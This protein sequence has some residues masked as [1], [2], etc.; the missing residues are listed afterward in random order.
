MLSLVRPFLVAHVPL[1]IASL[2][3][4]DSQ[5][6]SDLMIHFHQRRKSENL[7]SIRALQQS[8]LQM[9]NGLNNQYKHPYYWAAFLATGG[10]AGF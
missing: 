6:T 7:S 5:A 8:Q 1:V 9:I 4:V 2:W 10:K 3:Q